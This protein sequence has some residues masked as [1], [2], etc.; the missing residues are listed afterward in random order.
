MI[1][2][3]PTLIEAILSAS[4]RDPTFFSRRE[5]MDLVYSISSEVGSIKRI[6]YYLLYFYITWRHVSYSISGGVEYT[7]SIPIGID[8]PSSQDENCFDGIPLA[9][10]AVSNNKVSIPFEIY[11]HNTVVETGIYGSLDRS[12]A[13]ED[14][15][16][17]DTV[18]KLSPWLGWFEGKFPSVEK[19]RSGTVFT[20]EY[21]DNTSEHWYIEFFHNTVP[22]HSIESRALDFGS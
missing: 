16:I 7:F 11:D 19:T 9:T 2:S 22:N 10:V 1:K 3:H 6:W 17:G 21:E 20:I 12:Y 14:S 4:N 15:T 5:T 18:Q 13:S 8:T